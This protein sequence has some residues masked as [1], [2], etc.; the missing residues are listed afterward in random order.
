MRNVFLLFVAGCLT[1]YS[2]F[3]FAAE[4]MIHNAYARASFPMAQTGAVYVSIHNASPAPV[5]LSR[6]SVSSD[7]A[8]E[9][10]IHTSEMQND[11]MRMREV[12][13]GITIDADAM[14]TM[15]SGGY[16][17]MLIGL[18]KPLVEGDVF[19]LTLGFNDNTK[20]QADIEVKALNDEATHHHH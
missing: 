11:M 19:S 4:L 5:T 20:L 12:T 2:S 1:V 9:A 16:H 8:S 13:D 15:E 3:T 7:I 10:Q 14:L 6:V 18:K 17:I